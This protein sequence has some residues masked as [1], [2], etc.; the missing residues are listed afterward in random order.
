MA[1]CE[2]D[3]R[4]HVVK[5]RLILPSAVVVYLPFESPRALHQMDEHLYVCLLYYI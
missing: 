4:L 3:K 2:A 1:F 5:L